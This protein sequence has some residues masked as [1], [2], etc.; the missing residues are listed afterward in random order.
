MTDS[1]T[2]SNVTSTEAGRLRQLAH[3]LRTP[4]SIISM[5][6]EILKQV[7][8]DDEQFAHMLKMITTEGVEPL[9]TMIADLANH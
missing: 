7:R 5:G 8:H 2:N 6:L 4:L 1:A 3:D 9:K